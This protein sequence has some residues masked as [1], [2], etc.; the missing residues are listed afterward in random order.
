MKNITEDQFYDLFNLIDN[1]IDLNAAFGGKMFETYG[2]ELAFVQ[3]MAKQNR[4][5]TIVETDEAEEGD[6][7]IPMMYYVSGYHVVN[8][9]G[10]LITD[11]P[12]D[13]EFECVLGESLWIWS[14]HWT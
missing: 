12:I 11:A 9:I 10:Y 8:R 5:I 14:A 2:P 7:V 13:F 4:V 3:Q 1:K 6:V